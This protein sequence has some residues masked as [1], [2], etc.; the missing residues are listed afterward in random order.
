MPPTYRFSGVRGLQALEPFEATGWDA[1]DQHH[2]PD[3]KKPYVFL[4]L[5]TSSHR[6]LP[7]EAQPWQE[8]LLEAMEPPE[9]TDW[10][11]YV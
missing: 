2:H 10:E 9:A 3:K 5:G 1:L 7:Y 11:S 8:T 4:N 6:C